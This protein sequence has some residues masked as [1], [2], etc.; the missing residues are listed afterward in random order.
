MRACCR[1]LVV[2]RGEGIYCITGLDWIRDISGLLTIPLMYRPLCLSFIYSDVDDSEAY[3]VSFT[4]FIGL[5]GMGRRHASR[6]VIQLTPIRSITYIMISK[7]FEDHAY[8]R[9]SH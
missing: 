6:I 7:R 5:D 4:R 1:G 8:V 2:W 9:S 3:H